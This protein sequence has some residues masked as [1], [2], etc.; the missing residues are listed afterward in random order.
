M[1]PQALNYA[2]HLR[3][4]LICYV[5]FVMFCGSDTILFFGSLLIFISFG[6]TR[7]GVGTNTDIIYNWQL[8]YCNVVFP[9]MYLMQ[10]IAL[11]L[12]I[13]YLINLCTVTNIKDQSSEINYSP[14]INR[15]YF[16][17]NCHLYVLH[18]FVI[19]FFFRF[20]LFWASNKRILEVQCD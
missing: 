10:N 2:Q 16:L 5:A 15:Y 8:Q 13:I 3:I 17:F 19:L 12:R 7:M 11:Q 4:W 18:V 14:M 9:Q 20:W 1:G 6:T